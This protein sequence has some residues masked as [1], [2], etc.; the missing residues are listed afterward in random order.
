MELSDIVLNIQKRKKK[1]FVS[2]I[3]DGISK[4]EDIIL[5]MKSSD[6]VKVHSFGRLCQ[7]EECICAKINY[8]RKRTLDPRLLFTFNMGSA[9]GDMIR[10][11]WLGP[12]QYLIGEWKCL[13]CGVHMGDESRIRMPSKCKMCGNDKFTY[14][15]EDVVSK[16]YGIIGHPDA[17]L[18]EN[19]QYYIGEI[20][21]V[22][23]IGY[24]N[25]RRSGYSINSIDPTYLLQLRIYMWLTQ[26]NDGMFIFINKDASP[27]RQTNDYLTVIKV[28]HNQEIINERVINWIESLRDLLEKGK[29]PQREICMRLTDKRAKD[30]EVA[31]RCF[32]GRF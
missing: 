5:P 3:F 15:E 23:S 28:K 11:E 21:T 19:C 9:L 24:T 32:Y 8:I 22:R 4:R 27:L 26:Y 20:K 30:C 17:F 13:S 12:G 31:H 25:L 16:K 18:I 14:I 6:F 1:D 7:R 29:V 10:D 2:K